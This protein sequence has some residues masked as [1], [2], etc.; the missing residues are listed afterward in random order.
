MKYLR[1]TTEPDVDAAPRIF[2]LL[3]ASPDVSEARALDWTFA[4]PE[5]PIVL[6]VVDGDHERVHSELADAPEVIDIDLTII[7]EEQFYLLVTLRPAA[8]PPMQEVFE[9]AT[10][11]GLLVVK[12]VVLRDGRV[13]FD[14]VGEPA[15]LQGTIEGFPSLIDV[16]VREIGEYVGGEAT[17]AAQLSDRQREAVQI[18]LDLGYYD[19]PR[20]ATNTEVAERLGCASSTASEHLRKAEAKLVRATMGSAIQTEPN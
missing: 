15:V 8:V 4:N 18:A 1:M 6:F 7:D 19:I 17:A 14:L 3:V 9:T 10:R 12:P 11:E 13:Y 2:R 20:Q 5:R 16:T